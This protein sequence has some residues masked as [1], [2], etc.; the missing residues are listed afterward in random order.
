M[1]LNTQFDVMGNRSIFAGIR[2]IPW[3]YGETGCDFD[4]KLP[5]IPPEYQLHLHQ[6]HSACPY[7]ARTQGGN[8]PELFI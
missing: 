2:H 7:G 8:V 3:L 6:V 1:Q 4:R 5:Q